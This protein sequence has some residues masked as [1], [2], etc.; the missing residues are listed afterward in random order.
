MLSLLIGQKGKQLLQPRNRSWTAA[1]VR[2]AWC[3]ARHNEAE[4]WTYCNEL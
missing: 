2:A 3:L 4:W 1:R